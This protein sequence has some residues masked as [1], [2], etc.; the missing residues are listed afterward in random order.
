MLRIIEGLN[1]IQ[2][3]VFDNVRDLCLKKIL[4][5]NPKLKEFHIFITGDAGIGKSQLFKAINFKSSVFSGIASSP[6][7]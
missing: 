3:R 6:D 1:D 4:I 7:D 5:I 2:Q